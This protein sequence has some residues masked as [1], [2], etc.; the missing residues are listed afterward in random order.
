M[1]TNL[2]A[3]GEVGNRAFFFVRLFDRR[4]LNFVLLDVVFDIFNPKRA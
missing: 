1:T 4:T 2:P 3:V